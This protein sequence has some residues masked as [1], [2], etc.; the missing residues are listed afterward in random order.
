MLTQL[1]SG[2][3]EEVRSIVVVEPESIGKHTH[4]FDARRSAKT[5]FH[6]A[7]RTGADTGAF[8]QFLLAQAC[9]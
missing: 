8:G 2:S 1:R 3:G 6:V 5:A 4:G 7:D 9:G